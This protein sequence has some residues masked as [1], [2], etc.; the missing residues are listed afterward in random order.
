MRAIRYPLVVQDLEAE[1]KRWQTPP[2]V[3]QVRPTHCTWCKAASQPV[4]KPLVLVG[5]GVRERQLRGPLRPQGPPRLVVVFVRRFL[6]RQCDRTLTVG[7]EPRQR[8]RLY[9]ASTIMLALVLWSLCGLGSEALRE[10]LCP[11]AETAA[12]SWTTLGHWVKAALQGRLWPL[13]GTPLG[14]GS[15]QEQVARLTQQWVGQELGESPQE[16]A[17]RAFCTARGMG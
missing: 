13:A 16:F 17:H 7:P 11:W 8:Q 15:L 10:R 3:A 4:G 14:K 12:G 1:I 2:P 6:C 5:H 9:S